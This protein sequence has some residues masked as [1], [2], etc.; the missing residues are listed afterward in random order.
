M[1]KISSLVNFGVPPYLKRG[2]FSNYQ[3]I[4]HAGNTYA[5]YTCL[6][7]IYIWVIYLFYSHSLT[8]NDMSKIFSP[9]FPKQLSTSFLNRCREKN[10]CFTN[11]H[12]N[13]DYRLK[14]PNLLNMNVMKIYLS[15][16]VHHMWYKKRIISITF[17]LLKISLSL[18]QR[19]F[20]GIF[21][22]PPY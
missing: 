8:L 19:T 16:T 17:I 15:M 12:K 20:W 6:V 14:N 7:L 11:Y 5:W 1:V 22:C 2:Q 9:F 13:F 10:T 3:F 21:P 4:P 18:P